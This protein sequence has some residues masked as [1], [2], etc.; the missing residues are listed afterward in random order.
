MPRNREGM[1]IGKQAKGGRL[2]R[3]AFY[4]GPHRLGTVQ[5]MGIPRRDRT[6]RHSC[7][8]ACSPTAAVLVS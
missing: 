6:K 3:H 1:L 2:V 8:C 7:E 4:S 5:L